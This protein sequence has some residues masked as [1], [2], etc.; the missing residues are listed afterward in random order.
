MQY[1]RMTFGPAPNGKL[2]SGSTTMVLTPDNS[3]LKQF[4]GNTK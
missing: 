4:E 3:Y 1:Y 2:P